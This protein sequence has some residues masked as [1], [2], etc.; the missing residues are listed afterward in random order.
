MLNA[1]AKVPG[2]RDQNQL[3]DLRSSYKPESISGGRQSS[4]ISL[5]PV[6]RR[7]FFHSITYSTYR[8]TGLCIYLLALTG[9]L[10]YPSPH[11]PIC[12]NSLKTMAVQQFYR[13]PI[14]C[15]DYH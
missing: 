2:G 9:M 7:V 3:M 10:P 1:P 4:P 5:Q 11:V 12:T 14:H 13:F 15:R 8:E 6:V